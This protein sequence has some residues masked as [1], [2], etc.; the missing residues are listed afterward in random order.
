MCETRWIGTQ[1]GSDMNFTQRQFYDSEQRYGAVSR[2]LHWSMALILVWQFASALS[3][4]L[5]EDTEVE[6]FLFGT[7]KIVGLLLLILVVARATWSL[8]NRGHRPPSLNA[9]A[10]LGHSAMYA[11]MVTIPLIAL[12]RQYGSGREFSPLGIQLMAGF[13]GGEV[14][15]MTAPANLLHGWLGWALLAMII[16]HITMVFIHRRRPADDDVLGRM[17]G[18]RQRSS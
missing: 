6:Q 4:W 1:I 10:Q 3:H 12:V 7:H 18:D 5:M 8:I 14:G 2:F 16:G 9:M 13:E 17:L 11:L 15:W